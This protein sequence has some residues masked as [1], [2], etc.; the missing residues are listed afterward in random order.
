MR[1]E[2]GEH[3]ITL[4]SSA[5]KPHQLSTDIGEGVSGIWLTLTRFLG[6]LSCSSFLLDFKSPSARVS[7]LALDQRRG[8]AQ[9]SAPI[10]F[11]VLLRRDEM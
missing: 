5:S 2:F 1:Q 7:P 10:P 6:L 4:P 3:E 11:M 8:Q 9:A